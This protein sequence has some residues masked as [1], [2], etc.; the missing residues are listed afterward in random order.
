MV[1]IGNQ[2]SCWAAK[3]TEPFD[4]AMAQ[5]F[6]AFEWFPDKKPGIGWDENDLP[7]PARSNIREI[8]RTH[9]IRLSV[10]ARWQANPLT[11]ESQDLFSKDVELARDLGAVLLNIHLVHESGL[12]AFV[13]AIASLIAQTSEAGLQL[14]IENTPHHSPEQ[15]NELFGLLQ[16][17]PSLATGHVGMCLDIGHA[18]LSSA[19]LNDYLG[20]Y[21]RLGPKV[22]I[23][24]AHLH[25]NWGDSD[26]HLPLF[27]GPAARDDSGIRGLVKRLK[28]RGFSGS[29][30]LEQWPQPP[31]LLNN[32]RDRL[33]ALWG[34]K[35]KLERQAKPAGQR[36]PEETVQVPGG[37]DLMSELVAG[38]R[39][40]H[41]WRE[42]LEL[43]RGLLARD[44]P[45]LTADDLVQIAIYLRFLGTGQIACAEDG[46]HFRPA[47][48]AKLAS[49]IHE[50]LAGLR[51][52]QNEFI[53][54]KIYP[55]LPSSAATFQRPEPLTRIRDIAHRNDIDSELKREI[56]TRLQNKLHRCAGPEDLATST[57]L[58]RRFTSE[59]AS[60]PAEFVEQFKIFH[61]ELKEFFN[62]H[63]LEERLG[64]LFEVADA[65]LQE[66][67]TRFLHK[68]DKTGLK[69]QLALMRHLTELR[70][71]F[72]T[73]LAQSSE[74]SVQEFIL[75]DIALEDFA[76]ALLSQIINSCENAGEEIAG[77]S[78][79]EALILSLRNLALS[80]VEPPESGA[81]GSELQAWA[82]CPS[83][84][85][86]EMLRRRAS[87]LRCRR[88]AEEFGARTVA[89]FSGKVEELG[90]A[91]KI[92]EHAVRVFSEADIRSHLVF[93]VS[94]L[95]DALLQE[96]RKR[97]KLQPWDVL[98]PGTAVGETRALGSL[99]DWNRTSDRP[100]VLLLR[101]ATGDEEIPKQVAGIALAHEMPHLAHL[102]VRARQAGVVFAT[103]E[104]SLE[105]ERLQSL[106]GK[107]ICFSAQPDKVAWE[108]R[109]G[110]EMLK[111]AASERSV[112][113]PEVRLASE[114]SWIA[115][116]KVT[117]DLAGGK[118]YGARRLTELAQDPK[119]GFHA[120][121][122]LAVPFGVLE[123]ALNANP[124]ISAEYRDL[125][126]WLNR[127]EPTEFKTG[128]E[129]A[130]EL[131][132]SVKVSDA[133]SAEVK[134]KFGQK[135]GLVVRSSANCEDLEEF[136]GAGLYQSVLNVPPTGVASA[137]LD[138]WSSLW[139]QRAAE[140]RR[141]A[142]VPHE[143]AHM[144]VLVQ[145]LVD[146]EF[147]FVLHTANPITQNRRELYAEVVVGLGETLASA[148]AAG[149]PYRLTCDKE[150]GSVT[151]LTFANFS[152]AARPAHKGGLSRE[153]LDYTKIEL[154]G[155]FGVLE[156][157]GEQL[158]SVGSFVER[159]LNGPQDIEGAVVQG[160]VYLVQARAQQGL[161][162]PNVP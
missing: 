62:A 22:P 38:D 77:K 24:H 153:T 80:G 140:S 59:G 149:S 110:K 26:S 15:F 85:R 74:P 82:D 96:L 8:A 13:Q 23:I 142:K 93:Q 150:S 32:A 106:N 156:K 36:A 121:S 44:K 84:G 7:S 67:I 9:G 66:L 83:E 21:D 143:Q 94:K 135:S 90:R 31:S 102:S 75:S 87:L 154:S 157:L 58:L 53:L 17:L 105:F 40:S 98:V 48:H 79:M 97:L 141:S 155:E 151:L 126:K 113:V 130:R 54:R 65:G 30:I 123:A 56:K 159:A 11:P 122:G 109:D 81:V 139:T 63:S 43:V 47:H 60:Y 70:R 49:Q 2:T 104:D 103:C 138:V 46:R 51:T 101:N 146:P 68:K 114:P 29:L 3:P 107:E 20:F 158:A 64:A 92:D 137:I 5:G 129:R 33:L 89:L 19:T 6:N 145:E 14:A 132:K 78:R 128:I 100:S 25:E 61:Q 55:W 144:A 134:H 112:R 118:A 4:Y 115:L 1:F 127:S 152:Q 162:V 86:R 136:A 160:V 124:A 34:P 69:D 42:K 27:T 117:T 18:N 35:A 12:P 41:S 120:P 131:I 91:L 28:Q 108:I 39:R 45:G 95:S 147:S 116:E 72:A 52:P 99:D 37:G 133:I 71:A 73:R 125:V 148:A 161:S 16:E 88:L 10:H 50:R 76:F 111:A 119:A 57:E